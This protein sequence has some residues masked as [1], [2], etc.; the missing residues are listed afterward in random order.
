VHKKHKM[1]I[2]WGTGI[3]A[4]LIFFVLLGISFV[5]FSLQYDVN[6]VHE[7]YYQK[8]A[9]YS[10]TIKEKQRSAKY[11]NLIFLTEKGDKI[12]INFPD[13]INTQTTTKGKV[14]FFR[15]SDREKDIT[16]EFSIENGMMK[17]NHSE[18]LQGRYLV[19]ISWIMKKEAYLVE[20]EYSVK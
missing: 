17:V 16:H 14:E 5:V 20:K 3:F 8:G 10:E 4:F 18:L 9:D 19:K 6:L 11:Q 1:K 7:E 15:P 13:D 12:E 2:S